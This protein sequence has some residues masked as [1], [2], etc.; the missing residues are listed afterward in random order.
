V[1]RQAVALR[2]LGYALLVAFALAGCGGRGGRAEAPIALVVDAPPPPPREEE[3]ELRLGYIWVRGRWEMRGG[4]WQWR[5]GRFER[6]RAGQV[7]IAGYW[8]LRADRYHWVAGRWR[9][10]RAKR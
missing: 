3:V 10:S 2:R 8:Q 7:W 9:A 1:A 4:Q 6:E 5:A